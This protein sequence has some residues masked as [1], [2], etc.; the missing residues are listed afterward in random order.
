MSHFR[1]NLRDVEFNLF[2]V[3][4][5][6]DYL[7]SGPFQSYDEDIVRDMLR[8]VDRV[9][10]EEFAASFVEADRTKLELVDGG[11][12][13]PDGVKASLDAFYG[14]DW[15][16]VAIPDSVGGAEAPP[17]AIRATQE[18]LVGANPT[19]YFYAIGALM[20][21]V[22]SQ[23]GT[24]EQIE[25]FAKRIV[26]RD[27]GGT[28][29]LTEPD[30]G[31]DVGAGVT[32]AIHVEGDTYHLEGVKRFITS[33]DDDY[34][35][36]IIHMVLA[37]REGGEPGTKGLSMF[38]V[39][40]FLV[41][42]DGTLGERN[43]VFPTRLED[44]MGIK[45]SATCELTFGAD[46]P[47]IGYLVGGV[48]NGI[49]Q[50]FQVIE[51]ARVLI[52]IKSASTLSTAYLNAL[53]FAKERIQGPDLTQIRNKTA[54]RVPIIRHPNVRR[55]LMDQKAWAE[56]MRALI[57][58]DAWV[59]DQT[60]LKPDDD[61]WHRLD[62]LL[63]PLVKGYCSEKA[64]DLLATSL[65]TLGGSGF[66]QDYPMEQYI[67]DAKIDTL[68][69]GTTGI[70]ALD[71]FFRKIVRDQGATLTRLVEDIR[72]F[73]KAGGADDPLAEER[74]MLGT[75]LDE[76]YA[77]VATMV[78]ALTAAQSEPAEVYKVGLHASALLEGLAE[79][80]IAW[81]LLVHAEI[82]GEALAAAPG[83]D[84]GFYEGKVA[85]A[86]W[87]AS[88]ALPRAALRRRLAEEEDGALMTLA[89]EAF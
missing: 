41:N 68:Y 15:D 40:K 8:E 85:S 44:K 89:D 23:V 10:R 35:E 79:L 22:I 50:M 27:W 62:D 45:G 71:L 88:R 65:Q 6:Q 72:E 58:Y 75:A 26:E 51:E 78:S 29:V 4:R 82:A 16:L 28:M 86:R 37:R 83:E 47:C 13:L 2:E 14:G 34:H 63:L 30:A 12:R 56:G 87:F 24:E 38:I 25:K 17:S 48:H 80:V 66:T 46:G 32:K 33:G 57:Y 55:M 67:R 31:T 39:P 1:S 69:E 76:G 53:D 11:V 49:R 54:P 9:A 64:Y 5:I 52:G 42:D 73:V 81:R 74:E 61:H 7:G 18:F 43:G 84:S 3:S 70:Q 59:Q 77:L 19:A 60:V 20:A 21:R 36:N